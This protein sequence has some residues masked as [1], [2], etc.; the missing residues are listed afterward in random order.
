MPLQRIRASALGLNDPAAASRL[1]AEGLRLHEGRT[2]LN[3]HAATASAV[4]VLEGELHIGVEDDDA[5][6]ATGDGVLLDAG[7]TYSLRADQ[8]TTA[9]VFALP[10]GSGGDPPADAEKPEAG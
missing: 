3:R 10:S 1:Q 4:I 7:A 6:L 2:M 9:F 5:V 8:D